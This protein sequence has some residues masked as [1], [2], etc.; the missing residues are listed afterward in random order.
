MHSCQLTVSFRHTLVRVCLPCLFLI[1]PLSGCQNSSEQVEVVWLEEPGTSSLKPNRNTQEQGK[2]SVTPVE[3]GFPSEQDPTDQR[4]L[5]YGI[6]VSLDGFRPFPDDDPWNTPIDEAPVDPKSDQILAY[7]GL[8]GTLH[9]DFGSGTWEGSKIGIPYIVVEGDQPRV[10]VEYEAYP[11]ES[12]PGPYPIPF[13]TPVEGDP[14]ERGDRHAIIVD[15]DNWVLY[16]LY[17][18]FPIAGG[19]SW[20][21]DSGAI[22][23]L[24]NNTQRPR[25]WTSADA[26]GLPIFPGLVRYDEVG[27]QKEIRHAI[28][29]TLAKTRRAFVAPATHWASSNEHHLLPPLGMRVR[30]KKDFEIS[31]HPADVQV[32]LRCLK[33]YGM[34]LADNGSDWFVSG[35]PDERWDNDELRHLRKIKAKHLEIIRMD[36]LTTPYNF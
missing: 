7:I 26:A 13:E 30:L 18:A 24:K 6:G 15:R 35:A 23:D 36:G 17:R 10:T 33:K 25:G 5:K 8:D 3:N 12:D 14:Y 32:I 21:A 22:F 11:E 31:E 9:P 20:R 2:S 4:S 34:I 19:A 1:F 27:I 29:F 28:R 16:E